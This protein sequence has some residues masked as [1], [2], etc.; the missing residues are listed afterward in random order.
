MLEL[1]I[2][3][4]GKNLSLELPMNINMLTGELRAIGITEPLEQIHRSE[5]LLQP[6]NELGEHFLRMVQPEDNLRSIALFCREPEVLAGESR[7]DLADLI[8]ADRFR[9][10][11]HMADY[12]QYGHDALD[13]LIRL[14]RD[15]RSVILPTTQIN[16]DPLRRAWEN[17]PTGRILTH[18]CFGAQT[19]MGL[20]RVAE[21]EVAPVSEFGRQ[22]IAE[23]QPWSDTVATLNEACSLAWKVPKAAA[24]LPQILHSART[25]EMPM[26]TETLSFYCPLFISEWDPGPEECA[27]VG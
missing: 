9:D 1:N 18:H 16:I 27:A 19:P 14:T 13:G 8:M 25:F 15:G 7:Q 10:L 5:Y 3:R 11:D 2:Q 21:M 22:L 26:E 6:T 4:N 12:L 23:L 24:L 20:T 17:A